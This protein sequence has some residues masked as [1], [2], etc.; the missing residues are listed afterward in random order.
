MFKSALC[1]PVAALWP[2]TSDPRRPRATPITC[3]VSR[4]GLTLSLGAI[5]ALTATGSAT[6]ASAQSPILRSVA[7]Q[8]LEFNATVVSGALPRPLHESDRFDVSTPFHIST[9]CNPFLNFRCT[10]LV[11]P[12]GGVTAIVP[13]FFSGDGTTDDPCTG[14]IASGRTWKVL[15]TPDRPGG[16]H[17]RIVVEAGSGNDLPIPRPINVSDEVA[18]PGSG[19]VVLYDATH[20][21]EVLPFDP[22]AP[23]FLGKG[24]LRFDPLGEVNYLTFSNASL[25]VSERYF[26]KTGTGSPENLLGYREFYRSDKDPNSGVLYGGP[27]HT[28][29]AVPANLAPAADHLGDWRPG[30]PEWITTYLER[31]GGSY[32]ERYIA[33]PAPNCANNSSPGRRAGHAI[34][35]A[36]RYLEQ[37]GV[38]S[39]Y[40]LPL[41][42]GGDGRDTHPFA[43]IPMA[44]VGG[45]APADP[46]AQLNYSVKRM[47]EWNTVFRFAMERGIMLNFMLWEQEHANLEWLGYGPDVPHYSGANQPP[48]GEMTWARRL[49]VKQMVARFGH[50]HALKWNLC[51]EASDPAQTNPYTGTTFTMQEIEGIAAWLTRWDAY[52]AHPVTIHTDSNEYS[53]Y[54]TILSQA[55]GSP[56]APWLQATSLHLDANEAQHLGSTGWQAPPS[57][58]VADYHRYSDFVEGARALFASHSPPGVVRRVVIDVDEPGGWVRGASG[59]S[60]FNTRFD[61][62]SY[63]SV[64][65]SAEGRR[66]TALYDILFSGGNVDWYAGWR[67]TTSHGTTY[68]GNER[69]G[70]ND[71]SLEEF[72]SRELL[73]TYSRHAAARL[74]S[75]PFWLGVPN[76]ARVTGEIDDGSTGQDYGGAEVFEHATTGGPAHANFHLVYYPTAHMNGAPDFGAVDMSYIANSARYVAYFVDPRDNS[77][78]SD[79][80]TGF[81]AA[82][83]TGG[84]FVPS[85]SPTVLTAFSAVSH[86]LMDVILVVSRL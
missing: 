83:L 72:R 43:D 14:E 77:V 9:N 70:G 6:H 60:D 47:Q 8:T 12:P 66:R 2:H 73:W 41:N 7:Q 58:H 20:R 11:T 30:D 15:F 48:Q 53:I 46:Y 36:L 5:A 45:L 16:W 13:G 31:S 76:D 81:R 64:L 75:V 17:V 62:A 21:V 49:Y 10:A 39:I 42:L 57:P 67:T 52:H 18:V 24:I 26:I 84:V 1:L 82:E 63:S 38:N 44:D 34:I 65:A 40:L 23:G 80:R 22:A 69:H 25:P 51:E 68:I 86:P 78:F 29:A 59:Y 85:A 35:G 61:D 3:V 74:R 28:F 27:L 79:S 71:V 54:D 19:T 55:S 50:L 37:Q 32:I 56:R 4:F 33:G